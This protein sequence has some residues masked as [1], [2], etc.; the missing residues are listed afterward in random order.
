L[1]TLSGVPCTCIYSALDPAARKINLE[2]FRRRKCLVMIVTDIAARG[3]D[4]PELDNVINYHFPPQGKL[5]IHRVGGSFFEFFAS[6]G[7]SLPRADS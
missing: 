4:I 2:K 1:L 3:V 6:E 5:F 7:K